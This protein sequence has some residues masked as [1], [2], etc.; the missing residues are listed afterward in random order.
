M[1]NNIITNTLIS[2]AAVDSLEI[3]LLFCF[4]VFLESGFSV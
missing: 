1:K 4:V 3:T 2:S